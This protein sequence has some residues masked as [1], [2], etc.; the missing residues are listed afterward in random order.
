MANKYIEE[1][2]TSLVMKKMEIKVTLRFHLTPVKIAIIT[3]TTTNV[4]ENEGG[5]RTLIH[6]WWECKLA[7]PLW[8]S[9]WRFFRKVK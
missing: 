5:K 2:S 6:C 4:S 3:Q 8:K 7:Q 9:I 1:F